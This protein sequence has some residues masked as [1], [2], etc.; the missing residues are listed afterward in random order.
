MRSHEL[1]LSIPGG[2]N[3]PTNGIKFSFETD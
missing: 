3:C 2:R 1:K